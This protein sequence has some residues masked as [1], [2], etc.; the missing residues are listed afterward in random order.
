[1]QTWKIKRKSV[2]KTKKPWA[3]RIIGVLM[4]VLTLVFAGYDF[5]QL[6]NQA[7]RAVSLDGMKIAETPFRLGLDLQ[8]GTHLVYEADMTEIPATERVNALDGVK[9]VIERRVNSFGVSEPIVQTISTGGTYRL[10]IELAGI[11]DVTQAIEQIGKTPVLEFKEPVKEPGRALTDD[12]KTQ[13]KEMQKNDRASANAVLDRALAGEDFDKLISENSKVPLAK[14]TIKNITANSQFSDYFIQAKQKKLKA[15]QISNS[16][17]ETNEGISIF[18]VEEV[19]DTKEM[20]LSHVLVCYEGKLRCEKPIPEIEASIKI[21]NLKKSAT[22]ESFST[23]EG[24]EDLGWATPDKYVDAFALAAL[25]TPVGEISDVVESEFGFH[26][27]YKRDERPVSA[28]TVKRILMP[29]TT[30]ADIVPSSPWKNT[31]LSGK[32]LKRASVQFDQRSGAPNVLLDFND[33]G[34]DL[35][36][37]LTE[38]HVGEP[39]AIFLDGGLISAPRVQQAIYGGQAVITSDFTVDEARLL[40]QDLNAGALPVPINLVSQQ[41]VGPTL[42]AVSLAKSINAGLI[43][44]ILVGL[45]MLVFYRLPGLIAT[46][47]LLFFAVINLAAYR[48]F[49]VTITLAGIAGF[50]LS[51]GMA[52]DANVLIFERLKEE[53][54]SGRDFG[55]ATDEAFTRAWTSIRDGNLTTLIAAAVLYWFSS[56]FIR[57][58]ALTLAIGV[59]LSMFSAIMVS[60]VYL[61]NVLAWKWARKFALFCVKKSNNAR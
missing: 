6:W 43:G 42:G 5:P 35:F 54:H 28:V 58:F 7:V 52:V 29:F 4:I 22:P 50:V 19:G 51:I 2:N 10:V 20:L 56:S 24:V 3:R 13:L 38:A 33:E 15:G 30:E 44:L 48:F 32:H 59:I 17:L 60:R 12:E 8:G 25:S 55:S 11:K 14:S 37:K 53:L 36:G 41:T 16:V 26:I 23:L 61:K 47:A 21:Q 40:A 45:F 46:L 31:A 27:I 39:I 57:G 9:N 34:S 1:M 18:R 49:D